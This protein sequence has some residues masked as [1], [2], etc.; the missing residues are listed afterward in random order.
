MLRKI[1]LAALA[2]CLNL[3]WSSTALASVVERVVAVVG[4]RAILLS[5]L[6][7]RSRPFLMRVFL[8]VPKGAQRS[9]A[10]S[11]TY[12]TVLERMVDEELQQRAANRRRVIVSAKE[13]DSSDLTNRGAKRT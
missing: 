4:E 7:K 11:Q 8:Q 12:K 9:A 10:I 5:D 1:A 2:V 3:S 6:R 13:V